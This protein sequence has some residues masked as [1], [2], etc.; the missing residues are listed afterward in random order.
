MVSAR[1]HRLASAQ[2]VGAL[3]Q[4]GTVQR[5]F[6]HAPPHGAWVTMGYGGYSRVP[7]TLQRLPKCMLGGGDLPTPFPRGGG[8]LRRLRSGRPTCVSPVC[9]WMGVVPSLSQL[10]CLP[11]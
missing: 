8:G 2:E 11:C 10:R 6:A 9:G 1:C 4:T 3:F 5:F 7:D